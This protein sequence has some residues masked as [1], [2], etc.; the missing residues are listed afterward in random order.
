MIKRIFDILVSVL[1]LI[2]LLVPMLLIAF[3]IRVC[4]PGK[5]IFR[6]RRA[7]RNGKPFT[8]L[9]FRTMRDDSDPYG[10]SPHSGDDPRLTR[11]GKFLRETSLDELPQV[12]NVLA[13]QMSLVGPR[14]LYERQAAEW[15]DVQRRR[16]EVRP[17][18]TGYA[19]AYGRGQLTIEEKI[20]MDVHYVDNRSFWFD[21]R[22]ILRTAG[23]IFRP[24]NEVYEKQYSSDREY[25]ND[26]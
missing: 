6:Q 5:A 12:F 11:L 3:L 20:E 8:I 10:S 14:P 13:G 19:Q 18:I 24:R 15:D 9:K 17:G 2:V 26:Q 23:N 4:S 25:E 21:L 16:L 22:I 1:V 7:G